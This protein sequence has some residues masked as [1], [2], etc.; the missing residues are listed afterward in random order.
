MGE[1]PRPD[2]LRAADDLSASLRALREWAGSPSYRDIRSAIVRARVARGI[3]ES[4]GLGTVHGYFKPGHRRLDAELVVDIVRALGVDQTGAIEW[5]H[6]CAVIAGRMSAAS[7][8][9]VTTRLPPDSPDFVGRDTELGR[10]TTAAGCR[11]ITGM[12]GAGKTQLALRAGH[13][14]LRQERYTA[15]HLVVDLRGYTTGAQPA[16]PAAV[17]DAFLRVLGVPGEQVQ[18]L[19]LA[20][21]TKAFRRLI[22]G[23][24]A[25]LLL[26]NALDEEQ[27]APLLPENESSL[28]LIT[29]RRRFRGLPTVPLH[30]FTRAEA[31][32]HLERVLGTSR[33]RAEPAAAT[34]IAELCGRLPLD[35][36][37]TA[38]HLRRK[39]TWSLADHVAR[40]RSFE[41]DEGVRTAFT[42]SK[43][44]LP[45]VPQRVFRLLA[46]HPGAD[47]T[48]ADAA[49]L[50]DVD[51]DVAADA[52]DELS[53]EH[54][55]ECRTPGR[56][57]FHDLL[58]I[59][60]ARLTRDE[61]SETERRESLAR[62]AGH[63]LQVAHSAT[64]LSYPHEDTSRPRLPVPPAFDDPTKARTWLNTE[65]PNLLALLP[66]D[67]PG[68][69]QA[70]SATL[71]HHLHTQS[72]NTEA[73][74]LHSRALELAVAAGDLQGE[75]HAL[76]AYATA[77]GQL[78]RYDEALSLFV[79][80][81]DGARTGNH[82]SAEASGW[83]GVG[84]IHR[85]QSAYAKAEAG[86]V[87]ALTLARDTGRRSLELSILIG[88]ADSHLMQGHHDKAE[89]GFT[90]ALKHAADLGHSA[91]TVEAWYGLGLLSQLRG[92]FETARE[93]Y[94]Q[95]VDIA[96][97]AGHTAGRLKGLRG[98]GHS[99]LM[100]GHHD[101]AAEHY[102][103][104][105]SLARAT[106]NQAAEASLLSH[107]GGLQRRQAHY[108]KAEI[109]YQQA[110]T[111]AQAVGDRNIHF[112][113]L[114]GLGRTAHSTGD[115][116]QAVLHHRTALDIAHELHQPTDEVRALDGLAHAH[117]ALDHPDLARQ[118]WTQ[119][120]QYL[121][122]LGCTAAEEVTA[123]AIR[124]NLRHLR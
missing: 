118:H 60:A 121:D 50:G 26:D 86:Y 19:D 70:L 33:V 108:R 10:L 52:L 91:A 92:E 69:A 120:L 14:L 103:H 122:R 90:D 35:L 67:I 65:L 42:A 39:A 99:H 110:R 81:I 119:A 8:V 98:L 80:A 54:L 9:E 47:F 95:A 96:G 30:A 72:R 115:L 5:R 41:R 56:Y 48:A 24:E 68:Y 59:Y 66:H 93:R 106:D 73:A 71:N 123:S 15:L 1:R 20:G 89:T 105:L 112:E 11:V 63:Y 22:A 53:L 101:Q 12:P 18:R 32:Q 117:H 23:T 107:L 61:D 4:P 79:R 31:M 109:S 2:G 100:L 46:L 27:I 87:R 13:V 62:L 124:D 58:R 64:A 36:A 104:A 40:L 97:E 57:R 44:N 75:I 82:H 21:R 34:D 84:E 45:A 17:L 37:L 51:V 78:G 94:R 49:A 55:L 76:N 116:H 16:D 102:E 29:S 38:A 113:A 28:T 114:Y 6:A 3:P 88:L 85:A 77:V 111:I 74:N 7:I 25:L 83:Y 43:D